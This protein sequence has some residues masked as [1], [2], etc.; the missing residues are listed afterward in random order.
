MTDNKIVLPQQIL[1]DYE[2]VTPEQMAVLRWNGWLF[3][4]RILKPKGLLKKDILEPHEETDA[5][6]L[7]NMYAFDNNM[8]RGS[9]KYALMEAVSVGAADPESVTHIDTFFDDLMA[10]EQGVKG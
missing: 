4:Q 3:L 7:A 5:E 8:M 6:Y 10:M 9:T 2:K 1:D